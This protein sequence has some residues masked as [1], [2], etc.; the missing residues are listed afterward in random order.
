MITTATV[1]IGHINLADMD[2]D[3]I[4]VSRAKTSALSSL[5]TNSTN[6]QATELYRRQAELK[7]VYAQLE[8]LKT[9]AMRRDNP[10]ISKRRGGRKS[11]HR[12]FS[13]QAFHSKHIA[14]NSQPTSASPAPK[15]VTRAS[16]GA[17]SSCAKLQSDLFSSKLSVQEEEDEQEASEISLSVGDSGQLAD[18]RV[19]VSGNAHLHGPDI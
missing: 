12:K 5:A 6:S 7:R 2:P 9:K 1:N 10:H 18:R 11:S 19:R 13:L 14:H 15:R 3:E 4:K 17:E 16:L 8:V